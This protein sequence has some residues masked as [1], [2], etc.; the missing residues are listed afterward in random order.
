MRRLSTVATLFVAISALALSI[1]A[2][3][4]PAQAATSTKNTKNA[5]RAAVDDPNLVRSGAIVLREGDTG[6]A[7][8]LIQQRLYN[9]ATTTRPQ[10][11]GYGPHV[12]GTYDADTRRQV[13]H[14]Q[15]KWGFAQTGQVNKQTF[16]KL[17]RLGT[18]DHVPAICKQKSRANA[19]CISKKQR[20]LRFFKHGELFL[21]ED[22][23]TSVPA[24]LTRTGNFHIF[25]K[26]WSVI[27]TDYHTWMPRAM[28]FSGGEAIHFSPFFGAPHYDGYNGGSHGCIGQ[29]SLKM[30]TKVFNM[31]PIGTL[32]KVY[33]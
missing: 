21:F 23:R 3:A 19:I 9:T 20:V 29:F 30:A 12:T 2:A 27:S 1:F 31:T 11:F 24:S 25:D 22:V 8:T 16:I 5:S 13:S 18:T 32:A 15:W 17:A 14:F 7:V 6:A 10:D 33:N 26:Q 28:F 4:A